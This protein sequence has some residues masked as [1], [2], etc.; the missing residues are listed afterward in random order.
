MA[1]H[2]VETMCCISYGISTIASSTLLQPNIDDKYS[3]EEGW[4]TLEHNQDNIATNIMLQ[5]EKKKVDRSSNYLLII[6]CK[7]QGINAIIF[8]SQSFPECRIIDNRRLYLRIARRSHGRVH[9]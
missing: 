5:N 1:P 2:A 9:L 8:G 3:A 7:K 6:K 4:L